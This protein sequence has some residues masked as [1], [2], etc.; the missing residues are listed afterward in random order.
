M[1]VCEEIEWQMTLVKTS[2][3]TE[4]TF[5]FKNIKIS[6]GK[7]TAGDVY[8]EGGA[9]RISALKGTCGPAGADD[10]VTPVSFEFSLPRNADRI[11]VFLAGYGFIPAAQSKAKFRGNFRAFTPDSGT[12]SGTGVVTGL[13][14]DPGD[15][16]TG[17]GMQT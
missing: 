4:Q 7:I 17:T 12:P 15:T 6:G 11:G 5:R 3:S 1:A 10:L 13:R 2:D 9:T 14:L 8:D 16:G